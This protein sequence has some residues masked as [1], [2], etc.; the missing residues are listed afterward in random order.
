MGIELSKTAGP[1]VERMTLY[2]GFNDADVLLEGLIPVTDREMARAVA[3][4]WEKDGDFYK[5]AEHVYQPL[6]RGF[7]PRERTRLNRVASRG[8]RS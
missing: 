7:I 3:E 2:V 8:R 6:K 1:H 5:D 4:G